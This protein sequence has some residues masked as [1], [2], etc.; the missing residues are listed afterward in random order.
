MVYR[1]L[2]TVSVDS[3]EDRT[4]DKGF[5]TSERVVAHEQAFLAHLEIFF[6]SYLVCDSYI[7]EGFIE[8]AGTM[9]MFRIHDAVI[10]LVLMD[11]S[12][13]EVDGEAWQFLAQLRTEYLVDIKQIIFSF[14]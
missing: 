7:F 1:H 9:E 3:S 5:R 8:K 11:T 14:V 12:L 13:K 10:D 2:E 6:T 4:Y